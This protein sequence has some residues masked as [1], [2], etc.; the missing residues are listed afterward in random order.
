M[1]VT[2]VLFEARLHAV[3]VP[4]QF[5]NCALCL[6]PCLP[7]CVLLVCACAGQWRHDPRLPKLG[8]RGLFDAQQLPPPPAESGGTSSRKQRAAGMSVVGEDAHRLW[9]YQLGV[10]EGDSEIP[11]GGGGGTGELRCGGQ[12]L[13]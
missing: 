12:Q 7:A 13:R 11:S 10:A 5:A 6:K 1:A 8:L 4:A 3:D 9:R 2:P